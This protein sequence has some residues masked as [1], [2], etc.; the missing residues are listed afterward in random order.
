M[1]HKHVR[2]ALYAR[3]STS[4]HG[5]DVGLQLEELRRVAQQ[6]RWKVVCE[7]VDEGV[8]G[9]KDSRPALNKMMMEARTGR[10]DLVVVWR[11]DRFARSTT[12]LLRALEEFRHLGVDFVSLRESVDTST[13]T[14]KMVF[15]F[16]AAVAEFER[17]LTVERVKAGVARAQ[18][19]GKHCGRPR[20]EL[21]LRAAQI[22]LEQG[23]SVRQVS[24]MLGVPRGT[25]RR[26][27]AETDEA[28]SKAPCRDDAGTPV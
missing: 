28:G 13:A 11:F 6:R 18:A 25:L 26:R 9:S 7:F 16:L 17:S 27:L 1:N 21:D 20:R 10:I 8:S 4:G 15:T 24:E 22:L 3:V 19:A 23:H 2:A 14:G 5:Q 12:H